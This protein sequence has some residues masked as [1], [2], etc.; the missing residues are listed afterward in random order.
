MDLS[1]ADDAL[2]RVEKL[3]TEKDYEA[4]IAL[5]QTISPGGPRDEQRQRLLAECRFRVFEASPPTPRQSGAWPTNVDD[6]F[7]A[8]VGI[9]EIHARDLDLASLSAGI[10][11]HGALI[12]RG[13]LDDA[14]ASEL[15][16]GIKTAMAARDAWKADRTSRSPY[17]ARMNL[18]GT[19][20]N[21]RDWVEMGGVWTAD[22]P[23]MLEKVI[24][25]F[26]SIGALDV[27]EQYFG[28]RPV[29]SVSK[30]TLRCVPHT[31]D[32]ADWHQDGAFLGTDIRSVNIWLSLSHCGRD[33]SGLEVY[34]RRVEHILP[35]GVGGAIFKWSLG[36]ETVA[37][38]V[39][40]V[41]TESPIFAPGD[42]IIFDHLFLHRTGLPK[43]MTKDR[44]AIESW[45][46]AP[47]GYPKDSGP[48]MV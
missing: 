28:E 7:A 6:P 27:I 9:P 21:A 14:R 3:M 24:A 19:I 16:E 8:I 2:G 43:G 47:S 46:F 20:A 40:D 12:V 44:Y 36:P 32:K 4:A 34:P 22:S 11:M 10:R 38:A 25:M 13:L 15:V 42:A 41:G 29:M 1:Q 37:E 31:I 48:L 33:A 17:Y 35:T 45:F 5:L 30:S 39:R 26:D 18:P 23:H